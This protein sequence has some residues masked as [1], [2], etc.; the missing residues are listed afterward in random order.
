MIKKIY[1]WFLNGYE[2]FPLEIQKKAMYL[3]TVVLLILIVDIVGFS[4][5]FLERRNLLLFTGDAIVFVTALIMLV[6]VKK[7]KYSAGIYLLLAAIPVVVIFHN[8]LN[9]FLSPDPVDTYRVFETSVFFISCMFLFALLSVRKRQVI[10]FMITGIV[11]T[12]AH[13]FIIIERF[14]Q[15]I[16]QPESLAG[17]LYL[18][19]ATSIAG[20]IA[21][22]IVYMLQDL[23]K[24]TQNQ[25]DIIVSQNSRLEKMVEK[26]TKSLQKSKD[27]LDKLIHIINNN[28][29]E[30]LRTISSS[31]GL[32]KKRI[33]EKYPGDATLTENLDS[34]MLGVAQMNKM[35]QSLTEYHRI[36]HRKKHIEYVDPNQTMHFII[37]S[38]DETIFKNKANIEY[39]NLPGVYT[40][41]RHLSMLLNHL[42]ENAIKYRKPDEN[43]VITI[44]GHQGEGE[45]IFSVQD[46]GI[47][48]DPEYREKVFGMFVRLGDRLDDSS[49]GIGLTICQKI[50]E[51]YDGRIWLESIPNY[52]TT[53]YFALPNL[54]SLIESGR[55]AV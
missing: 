31:S 20:T 19:L 45:T 42:I 28:F 37:Q 46:N 51:E 27:D 35:I 30:M 15:G 23:I 22:M 52:G 36:V 53:V 8:L 21:A 26:R 9:D 16:I 49:L 50:V 18:I 13:F 44:E 24:L 5:H 55:T 17:F 3:L 25:A 41:S 7:K 10:I 1:S 48:I 33:K 40:D 34:T 54:Q 47:G 14:Y 12:T 29:S 43:P 4:I 11:F 39:H 6:L 38:M 2:I 32:I